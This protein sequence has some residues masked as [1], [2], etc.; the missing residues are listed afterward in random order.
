MKK[1]RT[2]DMENE[3]SVT[4][5][6]I[7][8][9]DGLM[10][11]SEPLHYQAQDEVLKRRGLRMNMDVKRQT[12]GRSLKETVEVV[13]DRFGLTEEVEELMAERQQCFLKLAYQELQLKPGLMEL[14]CQLEPKVKM[15]VASSQQA[16]YIHWVLENFKLKQYFSAVLTAQDVQGRSKPDPTIFL[17]AAGQL[18]VLNQRCVVLE[19]AVNGVVAAKAA[20]MKAVAVCDGHFY[21]KEDF[22]MADVVVES[23]AE[24]SLITLGLEGGQH[25]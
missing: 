2:K 12:L 7:F 14:L 22:C 10:V 17:K 4:K 6:V 25:G 11:D 5:L 21:K 8:D 18:S 15:A 19:D 20:G 9:M 16:E 1:E 24:V 23:L 3:K 13:K